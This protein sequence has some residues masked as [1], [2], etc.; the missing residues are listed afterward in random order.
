[1][2]LEWWWGKIRYDRIKLKLGFDGW[3]DMRVIELKEVRI[4]FMFVGS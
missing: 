1:M 4:I 2:E 3:L